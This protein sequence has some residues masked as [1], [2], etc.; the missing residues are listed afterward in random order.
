MPSPPALDD[1]AAAWAGSG[2]MAL[3]GWP[4]EAPLPGPAAVLTIAVA[5]AAPFAPIDVGALLFGRAAL[6]GFGRRGRVSAGGSC[7][8]LRAA[9]GWAAVS[10]PRDEDGAAVP[11]IVAEPDPGPAWPALERWAATTPAAEVAARAQLLGVPA[12]ALGSIGADPDGPIRSTPVPGPRRRWPGRHP[13]VV[14]LSSLWAGP[15]CAYLL[16]R[17]GARVVKVESIDRPDGARGGNPAF[18]DWLHAGQEAVAL[19]LTTLDGRRD[20]QR[21]VAAA[22]VVIEASRPRAL[23]QLGVVAEEV[24]ARHGTTWVSITGYGRVGSDADRVAFG[25]DAAVAGGLVAWDRRGEP[26][27][28]GDAIADP[29][30]GLFAAGAAVAALDAGGGV[31]LDA[32][33]ARVAAHVA[34]SAGP[35]PASTGPERPALP[36]RAPSVARRARSLG[37]DT[38]AVLASLS[39]P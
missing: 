27:F 6:N 4:D 34:A 5:A 11:A 8:L 37:A 35:A 31:V 15:L 18:F 2:G 13:L 29:L 39:P 21:L 17:R 1:I 3:T 33:M 16:A 25:D 10:L 20:L 32:A 36:P 23:R 26:V 24:V 28:C 38:A 7:R 22:D 12:A 30:T 14:D 9:D 19:D